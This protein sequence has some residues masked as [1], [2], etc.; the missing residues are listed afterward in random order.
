MKT[1]QIQLLGLAAALVLG[2]TARALDPTHLAGKE[3]RFGHEVVSVGFS[4]PARV[5]SIVNLGTGTVY[6]A[7]NSASNTVA[8]AIS[9]GEALPIPAGQPFTIDNIPGG[10]ASIHIGSTAATN[11]VTYGVLP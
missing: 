7:V 6:V 10:I 8:A 11:A 5:V 2:L 3:L 1:V 9:A 4:S